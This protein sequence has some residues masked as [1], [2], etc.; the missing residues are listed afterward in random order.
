MEQADGLGIAIGQ[1]IRFIVPV[2]EYVGNYA[3]FSDFQVRLCGNK[4]GFH[5]QGA[6]FIDG[7]VMTVAVKVYRCPAYPQAISVRLRGGAVTF[8]FEVL[9]AHNQIQVISGFPDHDG[10][11]HHLF[12]GAEVIAGAACS[13]TSRR[14][15]CSKP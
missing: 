8:V 9:I 3:I 5:I 14:H 2:A 7:K 13:R 1:K 4:M 6:F 12:Q 10:T 11:K 15:R